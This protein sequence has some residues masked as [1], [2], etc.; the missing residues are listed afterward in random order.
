[1]LLLSTLGTQRGQPYRSLSR[2]SFH[3]A[4]DTSRGAVGNRPDGI[5]R[6][7]GVDFGRS[8]LLVSKYLSDYEESV[9]VRHCEGREGVAQ[10]V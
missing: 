2:A 7:M 5:V 8:C 3:G 6:K 1:M 10:V 4:G 9:P